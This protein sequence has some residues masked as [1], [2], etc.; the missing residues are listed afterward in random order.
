MVTLRVAMPN[1]VAETLQKL[2]TQVF[3]ILHLGPEELNPTSPAKMGV[4]V[5][6]PQSS[7]DPPDKNA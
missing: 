4:D 6:H 2:V 5:A 1:Q 7:S 3:G